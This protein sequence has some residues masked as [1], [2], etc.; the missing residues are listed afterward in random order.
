MATCLIEGPP[1]N[2]TTDPDIDSAVAHL[3]FA[4]HSDNIIEALVGAQGLIHYG[5]PRDNQSIVD[6]AVREPKV[7][8]F[9]ATD[10]IYNCSPNA[11]LT[12]QLMRAQAKDQMKDRLESA[13][14]RSEPQN[15]EKCDSA[16]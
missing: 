1:L 15:S 8:T 13:I 12:L 5:D 10:L 9:L 4:V 11:A 16:H 6:V 7:T 14:K 3:R 2:S